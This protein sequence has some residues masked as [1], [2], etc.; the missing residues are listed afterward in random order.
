MDTVIFF[1]GNFVSFDLETRFQEKEG[2][3]CRPI[4]LGTT[5]AKLY[6]VTGL[7]WPTST[8]SRTNRDYVHVGIDSDDN[9]EILS[10]IEVSVLFAC[11]LSP[12]GQLRYHPKRSYC[13]F[14]L[15]N[16]VNALLLVEVFNSSL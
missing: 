8:T 12:M 4:L 9:E 5:G 2:K 11:A 14:E 7:L 1:D 15:K 3:N 13:G 6:L 10:T 16:S